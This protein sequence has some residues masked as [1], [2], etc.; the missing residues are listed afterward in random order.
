MTR[1]LV[2]AEG[3]T[4]ETFVN[5]SLR[6]YLCSRGYHDVNTR[7]IGNSRQRAKRGGIKPWSTVKREIVRHLQEDKNCLATTMVDYFALPKDGPGAWP[8]RGEAH[9]PRS[10]EE[11]MLADIAKGYGN[12][13]ANRFI[14]F[15]TMHEFE[16]LLFS[17]CKRFA[18]SIA[19]PELA[20]KFQAIRNQFDTPEDIN[21]SPMTAPSK[22][23]EAIV[24][25]Y[26]KPFLGNIAALDIGVE[27]MGKECP[28]FAEWLDTLVAKAK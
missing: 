6:D 25:G 3:E 28:H 8:G 5:V 24:P 11:G 23:I 19:R 12:S 7:L 16:G 17:D 2:H 22:R 1:L 4:E 15:V 9:G 27:K 10:V 21:D 14:P 18:D 13:L 26:N 20:T